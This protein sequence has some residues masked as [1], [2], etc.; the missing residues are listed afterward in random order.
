MNE[1]KIPKNAVLDIL[2]QT[3][4]RS[5]TEIVK[6]YELLPEK[7]LEAEIKE[8]MKKIKD[9]KPGVI[10]GKLMAKHPNKIDGKKA[11]QIILKN[12]K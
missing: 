4:K 9:P 6:D 11:M 2:K 3:N 8:L 7:Q 1:D 10:M 12:T 5:I